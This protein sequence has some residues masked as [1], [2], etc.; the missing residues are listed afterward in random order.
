MY[1]GIDVGTQGSRAIAIDESGT[2]LASGSGEHALSTPRPGWTEQ[3]PE[4]WWR[5]VKLAVAE[6]GGKID[7]REVRGVGLTGQMHG[8]VFLDEGEQVIRPALLWND[9][10][11]AVQT[12]AMQDLAGDQ[13]MG[14]A[15]SP[16]ITG[17]QAPKILWLRD[18]EPENYARIESVLL[19]K[20]FVRLRMSGRRATDAADASGVLLLDVARRRWS[21]Q[22]LDAFQIPAHWLPEVF[23]GPQDTGG[24]NAAAA[25]ELGLPEGTPIA[26]GGGDNSAAAIGTGI[27]REGIVS[28]SIGTS[29]VVFAHAD[30]PV[31]D[32]GGR[33][34]TMC[35]SVPDA[36]HYMGVILSAG[37]SLRWLRDLLLDPAS[38]AR[39]VGEGD[40]YDLLTAAAAD[41]P[42]G[43][44]GLV[45][46]PY[47]TGERTPHL[48]P[49]AR[50][51]L[52][53]VTL[54]HSV[55]HVARA[56]IEGVTFAMADCLHL[57]SDLG[58]RADRVIATG[59]GAR[60]DFWVQTMA[61]VFG[62]PVQRTAS[63]EGPAFGAAILGAVAG[64]GHSDVQTAVDACVGYSELFEPDTGR[65]ESYRD[66]YGVFRALY[67]DHLREPSHQL[68]AL[69]RD[70]A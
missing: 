55:G 23:E 40:P 8:S 10:R 58:V 13:L 56:V 59:G 52:V 26:A 11:T 4:E 68:A 66:Y 38:G 49:D 60:S 3:D 6:L 57:I 25:A 29:G 36:F 22:L 28:A 67:R 41:A 16:A 70:D 46:L 27:V 65:V 39:V 54:R 47:L 32:P 2:I 53:G 7:L 9:Q 24:I 61:D 44:E 14:I 20:D 21:D 45:F 48:D 64:G 33:I 17:F 12:A 5:A 31:A 30:R 62:L 51:A 1:L 19:P 15:L 50:G 69:V 42:P 63:E 37:M 34:H 43:A 18:N 35:H